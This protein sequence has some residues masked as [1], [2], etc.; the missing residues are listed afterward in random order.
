M[1]TIGKISELRKE[2]EGK[3]KT[4]DEEEIHTLE[5]VELEE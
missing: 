1:A 2:I 4:M 5:I 3:M